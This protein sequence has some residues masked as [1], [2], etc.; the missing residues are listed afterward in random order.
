M[1]P[2]H[3]VRISNPKWGQLKHAEEEEVPQWYFI[4][5]HSE[6][7]T[8]SEAPHGKQKLV[9]GT[10]ALLFTFDCGYIPKGV[11]DAVITYL[12]AECSDWRLKTKYTCKNRVCFSFGSELV[13]LKHKHT[14]LEITM[15]S[16]HPDDK[17]WIAGSCKV[18]YSS[19]QNAIK[20]VAHTL[21]YIRNKEPIEPIPAFYCC[22][23]EYSNTTP[24][25]AIGE[26]VR[27]RTFFHCVQ[28]SCD[29]T[30]TSFWGLWTVASR[31]WCWSS[32]NRLV[33]MLPSVL[34]KL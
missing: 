33:S 1:H 11:F 18:V 23:K 7:T 12:E 21:R 10:P 22:D 29:I 17:E 4:M 2:I 24:H 34:C 3:N 31:W 30:M 16:S 32:S 26:I 5:Y 9:P 6:E 14:H 28:K 13:S 27:N 20:E 19:V 8:H 25:F 15:Y